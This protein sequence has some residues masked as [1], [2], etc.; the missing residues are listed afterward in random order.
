MVSSFLHSIEIL[1]GRDS[2]DVVV[3]DEA[4]VDY[5]LD[6]KNWTAL[7]DSLSWVRDIRWNLPKGAQAPMAKFVRLR[8]LHSDNQQG[9]GIREFAVNATG[10]TPALQ[11]KLLNTV[12]KL[13]N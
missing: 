9:V 2:R 8:K 4:A 1:Q 10:I 7:M 3:F 12:S 11:I 5:S 6:G 13:Y